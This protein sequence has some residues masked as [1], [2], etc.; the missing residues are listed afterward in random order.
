MRPRFGCK[1]ESD[2]QNVVQTARQTTVKT[3]DQSVWDSGGVQTQQSILTEYLGPN[4]QPH[5][6]YQ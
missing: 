4:L 2:G 6:T 3:V 5:T 1:L